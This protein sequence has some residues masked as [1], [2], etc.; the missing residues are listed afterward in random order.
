MLSDL[1]ETV[2]GMPE[3]ARTVVAAG[4]LALRHRHQALTSSTAA[5]VRIAADGGST[6]VPPAITVFIDLQEWDARANSLN[7]TSYSLLAGFAAKLAERMG[8]RRADGIVT[9]F[10]ALDDRAGPNDTRANAMVFAQVGVDP[11]PVP[12]DLTDVRIAIRQAL[13]TSREVP[14][15][16]LQLLPLVPLVPNPALKRVADVFFGTGTDLPVSCSNLGDI[17]PAVSRPDGTEAE[18]VILRG[19]DQNLQRADM[20]RAGGQLVV[21]AGRVGAKI[22]IAIIG[23]QPGAENSKPRLCELAAHTLADFDVAGVIV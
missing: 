17:D 18:Y 19:T 23:Y 1:R 9:L 21:V 16:T 12:V 5:P 3:T 2:K 15:E 7:G 4:K 8:R 10:I 22:S 6:L 14:D 11:T 13:K 20:E